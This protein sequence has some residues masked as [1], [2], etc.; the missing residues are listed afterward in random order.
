MKSIETRVE[1]KNGRS[2]R[3]TE[4]GDPHGLPVLILHGSP[5]SG[6]LYPPHAQAAL[7]RRIR[8]I[9]YDRPGYGGSTPDPGRNVAAAAS[10]A[11]ALADHLGID[12][13]AV[14]GESGGGPPALAC[15]ALLPRR[16]IAVASLASPA[17]YGSPGLDFTA[18]MGAANVEEIQTTLRGGPEYEQAAAAQIE[19]MRQSTPEQM[20]ATFSTLLSPVDTEALSGDVESFLFS[21]MQEGLRSGGRGYIDDDLAGVH[22]W[23]FDLSK[24]RTRAS[25]WHG[26]QDRFVPFSHGVWL[27]ENIPRAEPHLFDAEGHISLIARK[28]PDALAWIVAQTPR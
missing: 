13:F 7:A 19:G 20:R 9:G 26:R 28:T 24:I 4:S 8:L 23:G 15:G 10:D 25:V 1:T 5:G 18:G 27:S 16:V 12:R 3:V 6:T 22:P 17:P 21:T 14:V 2:L 11:E